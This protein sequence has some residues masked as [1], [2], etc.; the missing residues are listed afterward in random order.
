MPY[1][2][3]G[4]ALMFVCASGGAFDRARGQIETGGESGCARPRKE[5]NR[6][7]GARAQ[8]YFYFEFHRETRFYKAYIVG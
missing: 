8:L 4:A 2:P 6:A 7:R 1:S 3:T 5:I